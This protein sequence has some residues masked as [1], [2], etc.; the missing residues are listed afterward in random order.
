VSSHKP[1]PGHH[2]VVQVPRRFYMQLRSCDL[3]ILSV[4]PGIA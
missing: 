4:P 1:C 2:D 3:V